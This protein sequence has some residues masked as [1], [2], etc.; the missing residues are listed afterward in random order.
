MALGLVAAASCSDGAKKRRVMMPDAGDDAAAGAPDASGGSAGAPQ[1]EG[2]AAG[3]AESTAGAGGQSEGGAGGQ[4]DVGCTPDNCVGGVCLQGA[5]VPETTVSSDVNLSTASLTPGRT[6]AEAVAYSVLAI[7]GSSATLSAPPAAGCLAAGDEFLLINLQGTSAAHSN[8]GN[9]ELLRLSVVSGSDVTFTSPITRFYGST[10]SSN[11]G[12]GVTPTTQR[13]AL[14]RVPQ[15]GRLV[16]DT[17]ATITANAWDGVL[18]GV[19]ALRAQQLD[20]AGT[21]SAA[22]LG[23]RGGRWSEDDITCS[24]SILTESGESIGGKGAASTLHN[25][26][27]SGGIGAGTTSFNSDNVVV[28]TPGHAQA[29]ALGFNPKGR[30]IGEVGAAYGSAD[31]TQLTLGSGPGGGLA[32]IANPTVPTPYLFDGDPL[33][34]GGVALLLVDDLQVQASGSISASPPN[35]ARD[36]AFSGGYVFVRGSTLA[37]GSKRVTSLG[38]FGT[39][40]KGPFTGQQNQ[41]SPGYIVVSAATVTGTTDQPLHW[42]GH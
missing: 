14:I 40:P 19:L 22:A 6:C 41:A 39:V 17:G 13:V 16:V 21:V 37:L 26:G 11:L 36:V 1:A 24:D 18:G 15:F 9:W 29:G 10:A 3:A 4:P 34:A 8:V 7:S 28:S 42:L 33:Q 23:Y 32:C 5:C 35:A 2:G 31:A 12:L 30:T 25:L 20:L 27:A 38:S